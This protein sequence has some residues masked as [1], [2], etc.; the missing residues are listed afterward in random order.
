MTRL[1]LTVACLAAAC[2][3]WPASLAAKGSAP[4][5]IAALTKLDDGIAGKS[6]LTPVQRSQVSVD[7]DAIVI[8]NYLGTAAGT[9]TH[10]DV[11]RFLLCMNEQIQLARLAP[12]P[13]AKGLVTQGRRCLRKLSESHGAV[14]EDVETWLRRRRAAG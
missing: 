11:M 12:R 13:A 7:V 5:V 8:N 9:V 14:A 1:A 6:T 2:A 10:A 3:C 4:E